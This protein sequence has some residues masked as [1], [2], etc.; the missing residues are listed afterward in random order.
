MARLKGLAYLVLLFAFIGLFVWAY[1]G[2]PGT[3]T[4]TPQP[5]V[6]SLGRYGDYDFSV[7]SLEGHKE[8]SVTFSPVLKND[9]NVVLNALKEVMRNTYGDTYS[10]PVQPAVEQIN[11]APYITFTFGGAK[12]YFQLF[13]DGKGQVGAANFWREKQ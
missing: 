6:T 9:E 5:G 11:E 3:A 10:D 2:S 13:K 12:T 8:K 7:S 1:A 4:P